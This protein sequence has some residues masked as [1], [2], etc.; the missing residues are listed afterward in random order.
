[1]ASTTYWMWTALG[2]LAHLELE[3]EDVYEVSMTPAGISVVVGQLPK[4][5]WSKCSQNQ[6]WNWSAT[7]HT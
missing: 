7:S 4:M 1:M 2:V 5:G 6:V 3:L